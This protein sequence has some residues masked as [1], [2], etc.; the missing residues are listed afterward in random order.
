MN[1]KIEDLY[2]SELDTLRRFMNGEASRSSRNNGWSEK[3]KISEIER[4]PI[5]LTCDEKLTLQN[6]TREHI[7]PLCLGGVE[8]PKMSFRC[9]KTAI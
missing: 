1:Q 8:N 9:V 7:H 4:N 2:K 5:C 3:Q 6:L